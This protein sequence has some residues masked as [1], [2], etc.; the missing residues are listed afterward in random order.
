MGSPQRWNSHGRGIT[1]NELSSEE[2]KLQI[3]NFG[4]HKGLADAIY[5]YYNL[6]IDY[7]QRMDIKSALHSSKGLRR[8][9]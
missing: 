5:G 2:I 7:C 4:T 8:I 9:A 1:I 6:F 3:E